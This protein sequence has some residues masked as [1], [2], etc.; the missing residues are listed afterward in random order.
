MIN[1]IERAA[2]W[3]GYIAGAKAQRQK[4]TY[5]VVQAVKSRKGIERFL[6]KMDTEKFMLVGDYPHLNDL[7]KAEGKKFARMSEK[8]KR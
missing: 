2:Y 6:R 1:A 5:E 8:K 7:A 4:D 3:D